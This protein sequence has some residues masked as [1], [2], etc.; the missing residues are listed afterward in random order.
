MLEM[1]TEF[2]SRFL[3]DLDK[4][5]QTT[6]KRELIAIIDQ[7]EKAEQLSQIKT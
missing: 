1:V 2:T 4:V 7:V 6:V 3:K 5:N